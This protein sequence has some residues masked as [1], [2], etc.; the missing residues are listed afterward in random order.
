MNQPIPTT[1]GDLISAIS[2]TVNEEK[3]LTADD[4]DFLKKFL[5]ERLLARTNLVPSDS[6]EDAN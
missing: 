4:T 5:A 6:I 1:I 2:D 3:G